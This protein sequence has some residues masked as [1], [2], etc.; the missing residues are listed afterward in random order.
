[1]VSAKF[2]VSSGKSRGNGK[3]NDNA[4]LSA[5]DKQKAMELA[6][7]QV[8]KQFGKGAIMRLGESHVVDVEIIPTGC[9]SLD[10]ALGIGGIPRGRVIEMFGPES[11]GKTMTALHV[12]A[13]A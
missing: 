10:A 12:V 11:A 3:G 8:E 6:L 2:G 1:M 9:I 4:T 5:S 13:E 7:S